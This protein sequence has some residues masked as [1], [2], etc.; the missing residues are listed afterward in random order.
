MKSGLFPQFGLP[1]AD[2]DVTVALDEQGIPRLWFRS[3]GNPVVAL[4]LTGAS[5]LGQQMR[6][7]GDLQEQ[8]LAELIRAAQALKQPAGVYDTSRYGGAAY[9]GDGSEIAR[10]AA[11]RR[12]RAIAATQSGPVNPVDAVSPPP[13]SVGHVELQ[14]VGLG[15]TKP[16]QSLEAS[17]GGSG[18]MAI[19]GDV[20]GACLRWE[21][22][23]PVRLK[24]FSV[25]RVSGND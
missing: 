16:A 5:Q 21:C 22:P 14:A 9:G 3:A 11:V 2:C 20:R 7:A 15:D 25:L 18:G 12:G 17:F 10:N 6:A 23:G 13:T 8:D 4:D 1:D 19:G 24:V